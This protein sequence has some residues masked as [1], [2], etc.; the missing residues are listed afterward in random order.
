[1][2]Y[3]TTLS[4]C[5]TLRRLA[6]AVAPVLATLVALSLAPAALAEKADREKP[7]R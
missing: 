6:H 3:S 2:T 4:R 7:I 5:S 1:M